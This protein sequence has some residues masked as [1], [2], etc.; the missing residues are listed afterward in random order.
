VA[1]TIAAIAYLNGIGEPT[2]GFRLGDLARLMVIGVGEMGGV[3]AGFPIGSLLG[4][5]A[6]LLADRFGNRMLVVGG[7]L[8]WGGLVGIALAAARPESARSCH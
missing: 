6:I 3:L 2:L 1:L 7:L 5:V 8:Y 4:G